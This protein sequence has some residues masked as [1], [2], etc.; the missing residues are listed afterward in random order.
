[1][2]RRY[3]Y[4]AIAIKMLL[5]NT[6]SLP[7]EGEKKHFQ[8]HLTGNHNKK[9]HTERE[10]EA[11]RNQALRKGARAGTPAWKMFTHQ[12][13]ALHNHLRASSCYTSGHPFLPHGGSHHSLLAEGS[14]PSSVAGW[15]THT[16][17]AG[18]D[19]QG[20]R[21]AQSHN[22]LSYSQ[23]QA[24]TSSG[25]S[26]GSSSTNRLGLDASTA[27]HRSISSHL[28]SHP[29]P[30]KTQGS[31]TSTKDLPSWAW[32]HAA[33]LNGLLTKQVPRTQLRHVVLLSGKPPLVLPEGS[34]S[35]D[36]RKSAL[37]PFPWPEQH[38]QL[39]GG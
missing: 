13:F 21:G 8:P 5:F 23:L 31:R 30:S 33:C 7:K 28:C 3:V 38:V 16:G 15:Q 1:M 35:M 20:H 2:S 39:G 14:D 24:I 4:T 9:L 22:K 10:T 37:V 27:C 34:N 25:V 6:H 26:R 17:A 32:L 29:A 11:R 12:L 18:L 36:A 19:F